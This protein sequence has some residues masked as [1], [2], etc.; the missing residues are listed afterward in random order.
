MEIYLCSGITRKRF[1]AKQKKNYYNY[2]FTSNLNMPNAKDICVTYGMS[3]KRRKK[4]EALDMFI[5]TFIEA[6]VSGCRIQ[7]SLYFL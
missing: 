7:K 3:E 4:L 6:Y 1:C 2:S 5:N